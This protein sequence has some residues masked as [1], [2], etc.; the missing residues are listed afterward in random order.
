MQSGTYSNTS[1]FGLVRDLKQE[2]KTFVK[3]EVQLAKTEIS[4]NI[5]SMGRNGVSIAIGGFVA[6]AGA[7]LF[8]AGLAL[9]L[10]FLFEKL[11]LD[12]MLAGFIGFAVMGLIVA[13]VGYL[14][15]AKA[16]KGFSHTAVAPEKAV[17]S[18]KEFNHPGAHELKS[19]KQ[20]EKR[21]RKEQKAEMPKRSTEE[22]QASVIASEAAIGD[23]MH[24]I[25]RR[26]RPA[27]ANELF[28]NKFRRHPYSWNLVAMGTGLAGALFVKEKIRHRHNHHHHNGD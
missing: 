21:E 8:L 1:L 20:E 12:R 23:T 2:T 9:A 17:D 19:E 24:E 25:K 3:E 14:F 27:Y 5:A 18:L 16:L 10:A 26:L 7:I 15:I 22:I 11:G 13:G 4:E 28:K 6:Y